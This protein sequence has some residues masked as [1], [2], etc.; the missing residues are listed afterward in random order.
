[1]AHE[2]AEAGAQSEQV[3]SERVY[4][5]PL[6]SNNVQCA[7][8]NASVTDNVAPTAPRTFPFDE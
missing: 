1:V 2:P 6:P 5:G 4:E 8:T 7:A 3:L